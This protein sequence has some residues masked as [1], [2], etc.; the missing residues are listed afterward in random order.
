[1]LLVASM[2]AVALVV[3]ATLQYRW[4]GEVSEAEE[5]R[6]RAELTGASHRFAEDLGRPVA[7]LVS[8]FERASTDDLFERFAKWS[9]EASDPRLLAAIYVVRPDGT[10]GRLDLRGG[11]IAPAQWTPELQPLREPGLRSASGSPA[12]LPAIVLPLRPP[13][14]HRAFYSQRERSRIELLVARRIEPFG[15]VVLMLDREHLVR[16]TIPELVR[17]HFA[18]G[19]DDVAVVEGDRVVYRS[20]AA[21]PANGRVRADVETPLLAPRLAMPIEHQRLQRMEDAPSPRRRLLVRRHGAALAE[22]VASARRRNLAITGAVLALLAGS[23]TLMALLAQ[24]AEKLRQRQLE[25]VA[26]ITHELNTPLAAVSSA[27]QNLADGVITEPARVAEYGAMIVKESRRLIDT[28]SQVLAFAGLQERRQSRWQPID[29]AALVAEAVAQCRW[30]ADE[31]GIAI[32]SHAAG[33]LPPVTGDAA[34]L[35]GA[36]QNLVANAIKHGGDGGWVGVRAERDGEAVAITV[37]DRGRGVA[38]HEVSRLFEPFYRGAAASRVR[39]SGLG[40]TIVRQVARQHGG[41]VRVSSRRERG[42]AFTLSI[43][44]AAHA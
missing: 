17:R 7:R 6:V 3:L 42:A 19:V 35:T 15:L 1:M 25:F 41:S 33:P 38:A 37:E 26:G 28:V 36:V 34:A 23:F 43:P 5:Q 13:E 14:E 24:R 44:A 16:A 12:D 18:P 4:I 39:G 40:L 29:V 30:L 2:L 22:V 10:L 20:D 8:A 31:A 27:G 32:E 9:R 21:W 11:S